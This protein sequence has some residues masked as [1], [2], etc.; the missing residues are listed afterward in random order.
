LTAHRDPRLDRD[1][2][3]LLHGAGLIPT[4]RYLDAVQAVRDAPAWNA[5]A[6]GA[7]LALGA[8]QL[9]AGVVFF[10]AYNWN[11][12]TPF[13]RFGILEVSILISVIAALT[14]GLERALGKTL[15]IAASLLTGTLLAVIGQVY[16]TGADAYDL[17]AAWAV[18]I[19]P[20]VLASASA[21][22]WLMWL[23]ISL[24]A[25]VLY[26]RQV[27]QPLGAVSETELSVILAGLVGLV[28]GIRELAAGAGIDWIRRPWTRMLPLFAALL[29]L[30]MPALVWILEE[31]VEPLGLLMFVP[32]SLAALLGY[33]SGRA[34]LAAVSV[35]GG[36][37]ALAV[38]AGGARVLADTV[39][40]DWS[41]A[42]RILTSLGLL[43]LWCTLV[44]S[45]AVVLLNR[46][47]ARQRGPV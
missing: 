16:Q 22:H 27:L 6:R 33:G 28:L 40:F 46:L 18:L 26:W 9:L 5:W 32:A 24:T 38:M 25:Y 43:A 7:L 45:G 8:G 14:T 44:T 15:L 10:F 30:F 19:A 1:A 35:A 23:V 2:V 37:V 41:S 12:L 4:A 21:V 29:F 42:G 20:W 34:D 39:G 13:A 36:F 11:D 3:D 31:S 17:F 47:R